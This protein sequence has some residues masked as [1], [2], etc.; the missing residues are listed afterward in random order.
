MVTPLASTRRESRPR[1]DLDVH[2]RADEARR[3]QHDVESIYLIQRRCASREWIAKCCHCSICT[4]ESI[5]G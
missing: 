5:S 1:E 2:Q 3:H 4:A